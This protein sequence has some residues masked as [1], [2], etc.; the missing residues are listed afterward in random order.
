[1][2]HDQGLINLLNGLE[3]FYQYRKAG[4]GLERTTNVTQHWISYD[5]N[6]PFAY[7]LTT[8]E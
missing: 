2:V 3:K 8:V 6:R 7:L 4:K 5:K 1:M